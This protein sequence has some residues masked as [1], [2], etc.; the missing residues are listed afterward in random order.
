MMKTNSAVKKNWQE[1]EEIMVVQKEE[2]PIV[3]VT[4]KDQYR[5]EVRK[6]TIEGLMQN[7][8]P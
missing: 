4:K 5:E 1:N 8:V 2:T 3:G 7:R 6:A